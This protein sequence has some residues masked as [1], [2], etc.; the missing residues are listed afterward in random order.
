[1]SYSGL[2]SLERALLESL[3]IVVGQHSNTSQIWR[4][5]FVATNTDP[6]KPAKH[7]INVF[8]FP[9]LNN[10]LDDS[11][12]RN[13]NTD[14]RINS[15]VVYELVKIHIK[16][17][18]RAGWL[19]HENEAGQR[20]SQHSHV[21]HTFQNT[22]RLPSLK[23]SCGDYKTSHIDQN[24]IRTS[25]CANTLN[26]FHSLVSNLLGSYLVSQNAKST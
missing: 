12:Q 22:K 8:R 17:L 18:S 15:V 21:D 4:G 11:F 6:T 13:R 25:R 14:I 7:Y 10:Y 24:H 23:R 5:N 26:R 16:Q 3:R 2:I 19:R 9:K 1:M 20:Y